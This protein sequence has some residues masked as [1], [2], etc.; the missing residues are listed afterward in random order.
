MLNFGHL[1]LG[2]QRAKS[3]LIHNKAE[4]P[5]LYAI[6]KTGSVASGDLRFDLARY[7]VIRPYSSKE[8]S[9]LGVGREI[10]RF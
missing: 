6:Q 5:L 8:V 3:L 9:V 2:E 10:F 7:G 4:A 1:Q